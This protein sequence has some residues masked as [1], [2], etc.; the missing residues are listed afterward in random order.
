MIA[1]CF[2]DIHAH[3]Q[4][5]DDKVNLYFSTNCIMPDDTIDDSEKRHLK[6]VRCFIYL[7]VITV[8]DMKALIKYLNPLMPGGN[9]KVTHT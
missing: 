4:K 6:L 3:A 2:L 7:M 5:I 8:T 9:K 1:Q